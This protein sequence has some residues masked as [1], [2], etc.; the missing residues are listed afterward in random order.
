MCREHFVNL[1]I[2]VNVII[3]SNLPTFNIDI[4][5]YFCEV[6]LRKG[7]SDFFFSFTDGNFGN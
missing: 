4:L 7:F 3:K 2:E 5:T 1:S 6:T